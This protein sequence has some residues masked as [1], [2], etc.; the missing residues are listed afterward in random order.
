MY[1]PPYFK[2]NNI[3]E[4]KEFIRQ[5][6]FGILISEVN[7]K[8]WASHIPLILDKEGTKLTGH[9]SKGNLQWKEFD[10]TKEVL[11]VFRGPHGYISSSWY[12]HENVPT[13][14]Y[15]AVHVYGNIRTLEGDEVIESLR[16]LVNHHERDMPNPVTVEGMSQNFLEAEIRGI[17]AFEIT[18]KDIQA[19]YKLSQNRDSINHENIVRELEGSE[20]SISIA[21]AQ[22]MKKHKPTEE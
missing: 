7:Q 13:W 6:N 2:S 4:V 3:G 17:V 20:E 19:S 9:I 16:Q 5:N 15:I 10:S 21:L 11:V 8:P 1:T 22:E 18:I 14:N 12:N